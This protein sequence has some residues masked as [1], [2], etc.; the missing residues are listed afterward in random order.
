MTNNKMTNLS[1]LDAVLALLLL[2]FLELFAGVVLVDLGLGD[3][4]LFRGLSSLITVGIVSFQLLTK[5][6]IKPAEVFHFAS[7]SPKSLLIVTSGPVIL[8]V[9]G[10]SIMISELDNLLRSFYPPSDSLVNLFQ[11]MQLHGWEAA[12]LVLL[13]APLTEEVLFR[14]LILRGLLG[15]YEAPQAILRTAILFS[16]LHLNPYQLPGALLLGIFLGWLYVRFYSLWPCLLA[17]SAFNFLA[18]YGIGIEV[19]GYSNEGASFQPLFFD[20]MGILLTITGIIA[21]QKILGTTKNN[22]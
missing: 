1:F 17:H 9:I 3:S 20:F 2:I 14:G 18:L 10:M 5:L 4:I 15:N 19:E 8:A 7:C 6:R 22:G 12:F 13:V 16:L 11:S 21:L